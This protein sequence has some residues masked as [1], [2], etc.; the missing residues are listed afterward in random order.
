MWSAEC[1]LTTLGD[2][3]TRLVAFP[4]N[5]LAA[6]IRGYALDVWEEVDAPAARATR[7][8]DPRTCFRAALAALGDGRR[9]VSGA[10]RGEALLVWDL[11]PALALAPASSTPS[12][13]SPRTCAC[14][15]YMGVVTVLAAAPGGSGGRVA[16][17]TI[18]GTVGVWDADAGTPVWTRRGT[19]TQR[20]VALAVLDEREEGGD[21][22]GG[23]KDK[24]EGKG[25]RKDRCTGSLVSG[26]WDG[27]F[28]VWD[29]ATGARVATVRAAATARG[30]ITALAA[31][32]GR[33]LVVA[34]GEGAVQ[35]WMDDA[36]GAWA[37]ATTLRDA[38]WDG[39]GGYNAACDVAVLDGGRQMAVACWGAREAEVW[40]VETGVRMATLEHDGGRV[41]AVAALPDGRLATG[42]H[43][44]RIV[45]WGGAWA[46]RRHA[47]AARER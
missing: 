45:V 19:H 32:P 12:P 27:V 6:S 34:T 22:G 42:C 40:D 8:T 33:R 35:V 18:S 41:E 21:G 16:A 4:P 36:D 29:A 13:A 31:L 28:N 1:T 43:H 38:G 44:G 9:V 5:R 2:E 30:S 3:A 37:A 15:P 39:I 10:E 20:V 23:G 11:A 24:D 47:L 25:K 7:R 17:G 14:P 46:R 26:S